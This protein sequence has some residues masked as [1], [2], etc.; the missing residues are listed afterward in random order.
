MAYL[1]LC[2]LVISPF[3][4]CLPGTEL[5]ETLVTWILTWILGVVSKQLR[6]LHGQVGDSTTVVNSLSPQMSELVED[7]IAS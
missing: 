7:A 3:G 1:G 4:N 2:L 5:L 6:P